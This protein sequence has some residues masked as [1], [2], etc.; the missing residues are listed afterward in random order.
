MALSAAASVLV[1]PQP[2]VVVKGR[3]SLSLYNIYII[4][5]TYILYT[6]HNIIN[7]QSQLQKFTII[8]RV[9]SLPEPTIVMTI[10]VDVE[11]LWTRTVART[12][13]MSPATGFDNSLSFWNVLP[14]VLPEKVFSGY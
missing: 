12:P 1:I 4:L 13:I 3:L 5:Y 11:E 6:N 8:S 2:Q 7:P 9:H 10:D 14:A